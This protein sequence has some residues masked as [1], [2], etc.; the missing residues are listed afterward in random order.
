MKK[1]VDLK[2]ISKKEKYYYLNYSK[3]NISIRKKREKYSQKKWLEVDDF[4]NLLKKIPGIGAEFVTGSLAM[5]AAKKNDDIDFLIITKKNTLWLLRPLITLLALKK[6][7]ARFREFHADNTW[8]LN[9]WLEE[10]V[11]QIPPSM[12]SI[13]TAYEVCQAVPVL[14][15]NNTAK[16]FL[17]EN[18]WVKDYLPQFFQ[19]KLKQTVIPAP[20][21]SAGQAPAGIH[22]EN[23]QFADLVFWIPAYAGMTVTNVLAYLAQRL[24]MSS[25]MSHE[26]VDLKRAFFHPRDTKKIIFKRWK[27]SLEKL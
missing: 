22:T 18:S 4:L 10:D 6:G 16:K 3:N 12:R 25:H 21:R 26:K 20:H 2:I 9:M 5:N 14:D 24:Y 8:C 7:K 11:L 13:Y 27:K 23:K 1:L 15:K 17:S 19:Q